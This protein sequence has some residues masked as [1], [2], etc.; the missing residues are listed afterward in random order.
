MKNKWRILKISVTVVLLG[1]LLSFSLKRFSNKPVETIK[2]NLKETPVYFIDEKDVEAIVKK[3]NPSMKIGGINIPELEKKVNALAAVDSANVYLNL[4]GQLNL[5]VKQRV[6]VFRL[7]NAGNDFYVDEKGTE[8]PL[9]RNY[10]Y[11]CMLVMGPVKPSEYVAL[12]DL[13]KKIDQDSF[14]RKYFIGIRKEKNS[15]NLL[16]SDGSYKVE[17]GDLDNIEFKVK[18]FKAFV[19]KFLVYQDPQKYSKISVKYNNQIVTTL[20][21]AFAENDSILQ[22]GRKDLIKSFEA[23]ELH[24]KNQNAVTMPK[25]EV[26]EKKTVSATKKTTTKPKKEVSKAKPEKTKAKTQ[27]TAKKKTQ[28]KT[29]TKP[30][31][32][33]KIQIE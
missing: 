30:K 33:T 9:S 32:K 29:E 24:A 1:F 7:N 2:I 6:P 27:E 17:I 21:P 4:N 13:I 12:G 14:S 5:D 28:P 15:Y 22:V 25:T 31:K 19:E 11:P 20:N 26:K 10:S 23:S 18:G 3:E 16:T 8:F